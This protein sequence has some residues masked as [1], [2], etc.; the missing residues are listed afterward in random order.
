ML[1]GEFGVVSDRSRKR[2]INESTQSLGRIA[3]RTRLLRR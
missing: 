3:N 2:G 1:T